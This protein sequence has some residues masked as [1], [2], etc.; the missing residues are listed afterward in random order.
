[1]T[2][3][4]LTRR[5]EP[6][7]ML[8]PLQRS[9]GDVRLS[10]DRRESRTVLRDL[11]QSGSA[12]VGFVRVELG[13]APEAI[14]INTAGGLTDGDRLFHDVSW[15]A[16]TAAVVTSQ[17]AER[18]Y[19]SRADSAAIRARLDVEEGATAVWAPQETILFD[20]A[21]LDRR[22]EV[23]LAPGGALLACES[24][25]FGRAA[26][27]ETVRSGFVSDSWRI[28]SG[29]KLVFADCFR[30]DGAIEDALKRPALAGGARAMATVLYA[31]PDALAMRDGARGCLD[32]AAIRAGSTCL[33]LV[34]VVRLVAQGAFE[35][36]GAVIG[37][38]SHL[39]AR[40]NPAEA[41]GLPRVWS[42]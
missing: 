4:S 11:Y 30:L 13:S 35:L 2:R 40:L 41:V 24:L 33:G 9:E 1:M 26:M 12:K 14:L 15:R 39:M 32:G 16:G 17:A 21:R 34:T 28:R 23:E 36:R 19:R 37:V 29:G 27:G 22:N 38:L 42:L 6:D 25:V 10:F 18:I 31:G 3:E 5:P 7:R 20:G 8:E